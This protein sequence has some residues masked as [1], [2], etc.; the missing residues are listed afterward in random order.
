MRE[1]RILTALFF[2]ALIT[3]SLYSP[4]RNASQAS[5]EAFEGTGPVLQS[6]IIMQSAQDTFIKKKTSFLVISMLQIK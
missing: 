6:R 5:P 4:D 2:L 1:E 3:Q